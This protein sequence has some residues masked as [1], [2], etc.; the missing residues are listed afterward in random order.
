MFARSIDGGQTWQPAQDIHD[1]PNNDFNYGHQIVVLPDG[2]VIDAFCEGSYQNNA[3]AVLT[4]LRSTDHGQTWSAPIAAVPQEPLVAPNSIKPPNA[5]VTDP[6]TGQMID[7]HPMF[8][9]IAVDTH[10]GVLY[11][12][13]IDARFSNFQYNS[14]ALSM[15][16][17]GGLT[18][19]LPIQANQTPNTVPAIDRQAWNP[20][21]AV[22]ANGT[23]AV[24]YYDFRNNTPAPGALTD[25][26][27]AFAPAPA[28][29]P[30]TWNEVRLTNTSFDLEQAPSRPSFA[31]AKYF[32]GDY[33]G[34]AAAG[35]DF[36]A[37]W[38]MPNGT[39][40][41]QESIFFR[42]AVDPPDVVVPTSAGPSTAAPTSAPTSGSSILFTTYE[43][44]LNNSITVL[45][46][47]GTA[48]VVDSPTP[49]LWRESWLL[50]GIAEA[51][52]LNPLS[53][54]EANKGMHKVG[55]DPASNPFTDGLVNDLIAH[56]ITD[57]LVGP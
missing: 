37:V 23:V 43:D 26:W 25:Y 30:S 19:S 21:V 29:N 18:W 42:R 46:S 51:P 16:S 11:A 9:S 3:Q 33:E 1:A 34:L 55:S 4:L 5:L 44:V 40:A 6:D 20:T 8:S 15:S 36:I 38:G 28:T 47:T 57:S 48:S 35:N 22:A 31:P 45:T 2:M 10:S 24:T 13:W 17:D 12:V 50:A 56:S 39:G 14:I 49:S 32:L 53:V 41:N 27:L 54:V 7:T 52:T